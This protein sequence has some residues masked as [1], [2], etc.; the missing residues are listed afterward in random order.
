MPPHAL[1][2]IPRIK[3]R[4]FRVASGYHFQSN[5]TLPARLLA[6]DRQAPGV[7]ITGVASSSSDPEYENRIQAA[8][9]GVQ[10]GKYANLK[11]A[12]RKENVIYSIP[13]YAAVQGGS[14]RRHVR[15]RR[16]P[17][18]SI[19]RKRESSSSGWDNVPTQAFRSITVPSAAD[20]ASTR[21][22]RNQSTRFIKRHPELV[23]K[24]VK[25]NPQ[26]A[27]NFNEAVLKDE[28]VI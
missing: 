6:F 14:T 28:K 15:L 18:L 8:I 25:L 23:V 22:A 26:R 16:N 12:T 9:L 1:Q 10:E 3:Y 4:V 7:A 13:L 24:P 2:P 5:A 20:M 21:T 17:S 11:E 27:K 19:L